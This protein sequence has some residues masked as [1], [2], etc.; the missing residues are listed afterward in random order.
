MEKKFLKKSFWKK[1][2]AKEKK[3]EEIYAETWLKEQILQLKEYSIRNRS[4]T[5]LIANLEKQNQ[6]NKK[7]FLWIRSIIDTAI[8]V[9]KQKGY[10]IDRSIIKDYESECE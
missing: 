3:E 7:Q 1:K 8:I 10:N 5:E 2:F 6:I 9:Y 4:N